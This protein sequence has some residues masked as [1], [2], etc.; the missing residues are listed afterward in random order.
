MKDFMNLMKQ[1]QDMQKRMEEVQGQLNEIE[2]QGSS[3]AGMVEVTMS[4]KGDVKT[5]KIDPSLIKDNEI[6]ILEDLIVAALSDAKSKA[7]ETMKSKMQE[8]TGG[9]NLPQGINPFG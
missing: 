7:E 9:L 6:E 4:A 8:L 5:L 3:G 2:V 1:A